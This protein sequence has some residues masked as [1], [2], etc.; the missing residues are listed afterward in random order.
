[1]KTVLQ[2]ID[3]QRAKFIKRNSV[4]PDH[5]SL[6]YDTGL[7]LLK[8]LAQQ[9]NTLEDVIE[10]EGLLMRGDKQEIISKLESTT[11]YGVKIRIVDISVCDNHATI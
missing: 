9:G 10:I 11:V 6:T 2:S 3:W 8:E 1:M 4:E 5:V 7:Q